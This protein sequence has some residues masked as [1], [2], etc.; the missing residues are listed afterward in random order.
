MMCF[1]WY[2]KVLALLQVIQRRGRE[3]TVVVTT[4]SMEEVLLLS[5]FPRVQYFNFWIGIASLRWTLNPQHPKARCL[6]LCFR[7][8]PFVIA[9]LFRPRASRLIHIVESEV[10]KWSAQHDSK[11]IETEFGI[12]TKEVKPLWNIMKPLFKYG[13]AQLRYIW[14]SQDDFMRSS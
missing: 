6:V 12:R 8:R 10:V 11:Q 5:V 1:S 13:C 9:L 14:R 2:E 7:P 4:H 3:Q